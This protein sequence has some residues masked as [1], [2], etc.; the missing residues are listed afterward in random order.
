MRSFVTAAFLCTALLTAMLVPGVSRAASPR[1]SVITPRGIQRGTEGKLTFNGSPFKD[2]QEILFFSPGFT[3]TKLEPSD[4]AV[5]AHLK[6]APDCRLGEHVAHVRTA[7]GLSDYR[8]FYVGALPA[9]D[10]KEPNSQFDAPQQVPLNV[11]VAGVVDSE[12]VDYFVVEA[13]KGQRIA[14]EIEA[15]RGGQTLFD[16]YIAI[17][18]AKRFEL[19]ARDDTPLVKQ[20]AVAAVVAPADGKYIVQVRDSSYGGNGNCMYR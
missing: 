20:D 2:A 1:L 17:L 7:S 8:T 11:T 9:V 16:P 18:D 15:M 3:V 19:S 6:V 14:A 13:K 12:D 10:E 5:V 4:G